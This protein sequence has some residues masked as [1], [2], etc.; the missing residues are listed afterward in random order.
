MYQ[1]QDTV[2]VFAEPGA[3]IHAWRNCAASV[4]AKTV[5]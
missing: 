5:Y 2:S 4:N 3:G 1:Q